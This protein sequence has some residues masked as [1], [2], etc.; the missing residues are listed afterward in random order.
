M[1][2]EQIELGVQRVRRNSLTTTLRALSLRASRRSAVLVLV[3]RRAEGQLLAE[4]LGR[5]RLSRIA[6]A[7]SSSR[8]AR[9]TR[10]ARA[11]PPAAIVCMPTSSRQQPLTA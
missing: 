3:G 4:L 6:V 8:G 9:V 5:R 11:A 7:L 2:K 10:S 1:A